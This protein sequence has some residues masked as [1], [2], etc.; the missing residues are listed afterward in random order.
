MSL[1]ENLNKIENGIN[2]LWKNNAN[3]GN[4]RENHNLEFDKISL[5]ANDDKR[6]ISV[7]SI[8][9][10]TFGTKKDLASEKKRY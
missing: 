8:E 4:L 6:I 3:V 9:T 10:Y 5:S 2:H 1:N 7:D